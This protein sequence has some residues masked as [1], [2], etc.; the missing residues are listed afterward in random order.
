M[1]EGMQLDENGALTAWNGTDAL[2]NRVA[3]EFGA[4]DPDDPAY[5]L[6]TYCEYAELIP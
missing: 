6:Y 4:I 1:G 2:G 5:R 3:M